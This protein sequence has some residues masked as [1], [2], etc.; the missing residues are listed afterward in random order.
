VQMYTLIAISIEN[1]AIS[2]ACQE[3]ALG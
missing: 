1:R 2:V 3:T